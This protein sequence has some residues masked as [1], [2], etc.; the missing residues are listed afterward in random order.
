MSL[1]ACSLLISEILYLPSLTIRAA[2]IHPDHTTSFPSG[3]AN[4]FS[5]GFGFRNGCCD[6]FTNVRPLVQVTF[7]NDSLTSRQQIRRGLV[8]GKLVGQELFLA[9]AVAQKQERI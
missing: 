7:S 9:W 1:H 6:P 2:A 5:L 8:N 4:G 3:H